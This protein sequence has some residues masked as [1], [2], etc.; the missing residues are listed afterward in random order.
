MAAG[1]T[2][3]VITA[4]SLPALAVY[5]AG[6]ALCRSTGRA[7]ATMYISTAANVVNILG[8]C[9]GVF[10]LGL[11]AAGVAFPSLIARVLFAIA[12]TAYCFREKGPVRYRLLDIF[13]WDGGLLKKSWTS[14]CPTGWKTGCTSW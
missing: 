12:V 13:R 5:D 2:Y 8:N 6:A 11:G 14:P 3:L 7:G 1:L 4:W 9:V 10:V